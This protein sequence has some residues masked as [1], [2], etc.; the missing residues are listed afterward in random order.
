MDD[1][2][3]ELIYVKRLTP[4]SSCNLN[5]SGVYTFVEIDDKKGIRVSAVDS[6]DSEKPKI[7]REMRLDNSLGTQHL[8]AL[9]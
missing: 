6:V 2:Y 3:N 4:P 1:G 5:R 7:L 9:V 8:E